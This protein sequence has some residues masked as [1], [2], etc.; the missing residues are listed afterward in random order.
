M[1]PR[2]GVDSATSGIEEGPGRALIAMPETRLGAARLATIAGLSALT[3]GI[4]LGSSGR[5]T[6]HEAFVAQAAR[7]MIARV[8]VL[9]PTID[10]QSWLEK[11]PLAF[12]LVALAGRASGEVTEFV[13]RVPSAVAATLLALGVAV[14]TARR[15]GPDVGWL[16][17]LIQATTLW[18]VMRGRLAEADI[19]LACL[20]TWTMVA[21]DRLR[22]QPRRTEDSGL[23]TQDSGGGV[24]GPHLAL[25][26]SG[27]LSPWIGRRSLFL[28][29]IGGLADP[30]SSPLPLGEGPRVRG[31]ASPVVLEIDSPGYR[32]SGDVPHPGPLLLGEGGREAKLPVLRTDFAPTSP[33]APPSPF[34]RWAFFGALGAT[35][36]VKGLGFGAV[37]VGSAVV[38]VLAWDRDRS[39]IKA[40]MNAKG[41]ALAAVLALTWP[42]LVAMRLPA[43]VSLWTLHVTDRMAAH[44][45]HFIGGP[46]W[47]Y[48]PAVLGQ[49][50]PWTPLA[51]V[52]AWPSLLRAIKG[53]GGA[54]RLLW[55]WAVVPVLVLSTATVK[56]AHYAIHALPPLSAWASLGLVRVGLR[57]R[58]RGWSPDR[59]RRGSVALFVGLGLICGLGHLWLGP[60]FDRRG[61]EWASCEAIGRAVDSDLPL[62]FLYE[63]WDRKPYPT[64]FGPVP[65]DWAV[66][67]FYLKRPASWRQGVADLVARSPGPPGAPYALLGRDR[68]LPALRKLGR[69]E[70]LMKGPADRFDRTF[71]L[72][73]ITPRADPFAE[74]R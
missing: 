64:P 17:G 24:R 72:F 25:G 29:R 74:G 52:G 68:D 22:T 5:L 2:R 47:Q 69:V 20:V 31:A 26:R 6:Y 16:A 19:L 71:T 12:W 37:L 45:E 14:F 30:S 23:R 61:A 50:L 46:W 3:L 4:G 10:G 59:V 57:L 28:A 40:L 62:V 49:A 1:P 11:P 7:E 51:L 73:R 8:A 33:D 55:A 27:S 54:D 32:Q 41:W 48:G 43:A 39:A 13:A 44:P 36:L 53:R 42:V 38:V 58:R 70:T 63:D 34:W 21:F 65:H 66:R 15:F 67:L 9:V 56:N 18:T 35:A 60:R